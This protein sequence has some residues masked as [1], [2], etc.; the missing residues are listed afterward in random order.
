MGKHRNEYAGSESSWKRVDVYS[1]LRRLFSHLFERMIS[2][3]HTIRKTLCS[4][5]PGVISGADIRWRRRLVSLI[6]NNSSCL[7][8][9]TGQD[10]W[11]DFDQSFSLSW[12]DITAVFSSRCC[13]LPS[14]ISFALSGLGWSKHGWLGQ[15]LQCLTFYPDP[16]CFYSGAVKKKNKKHL[17]FWMKRK[18]CSFNLSRIT[19]WQM[20]TCKRNLSNLQSGLG[21]IARKG[22]ALSQFIVKYN[23]QAYKNRFHKCHKS[24]ASQNGRV[25]LQGYLLFPLLFW[26]YYCSWICF[27]IHVE[28]GGEHHPLHNPV[29]KFDNKYGSVPDWLV[30]CHGQTRPPEGTHCRLHTENCSLFGDSFPCWHQPARSVEPEE[31]TSAGC[32]RPAVI[33]LLSSHALLWGEE[34]YSSCLVLCSGITT[35]MPGTQRRPVG[36]GDLV[37]RWHTELIFYDAHVSAARSASLPNALNL[38]S[39]TFC[40]AAPLP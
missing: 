18:R 11:G 21:I 23:K 5:W 8:V 40:V 7:A 16:T 34:M 9:A 1:R 20:I 31:D 26:V 39:V 6:N 2:H 17:W 37:R 24:E 14:W 27:R 4:L 12:E 22:E 13:S 30:C 38:S 3:L 36:V 25:V 29:I 35:F 28:S 33:D 32:S 19:F 10:W 15:R